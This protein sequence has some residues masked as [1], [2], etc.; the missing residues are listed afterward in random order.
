MAL[1]SCK[2]EVSHHRVR[3]W[4]VFF[5]PKGTAWR[6][7][8]WSMNVA[9]ADTR[10]D[11]IT[12][13]WQYRERAPSPT[14]RCRVGSVARAGWMRRTGIR[15]GWTRGPRRRWRRNA[16]SDRRRCAVHGPELPGEPELPRWRHHDP[17]RHGVRPGGDLPLYGA[18]RLRSS[19]SR[20]AASA[21]RHGDAVVPR[22]VQT[23]RSPSSTWAVLRRGR[24]DRRHGTFTLS[25]RSHRAPSIP[26]VFQIGKWRRRVT[27]GHPDCAMTKVPASL[28]RL[29]RNQSEGDIPQMASVT[30]A[31]DELACLLR[32]HRPR[33]DGVHGAQRAEADCMSTG[34]PGPGPDLA[35]GG[36]GPAGDCSGAGCP[37][38]STKAAAR[39]VRPR[40]P[41]LR[42]RRAQRDQA[43]TWGRCTTGST[44]AAGSWRR[45]TR[46]PGSR[47]V[48]PISRA[49]RAG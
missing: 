5:W 44:R 12:L 36:A 3:C 40:A 30:G 33:C 41:G 19:R 6:A 45:T 1:G 38:W 39:E 28:S 22:F 25:E 43:A 49:S 26:V 17:H 46:T 11:V 37:L 23:R 2:S 14:S 7:P 13:A 8:R 42:V 15:R 35:G 47:T 29:P 16:G 24:R 4:K 31:C 20:G 27:R 32:A 9:R 48:P 18:H 21:R 34:A 10:R